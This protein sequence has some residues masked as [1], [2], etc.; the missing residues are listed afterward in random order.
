[1]R[2]VS[3]PSKNLTIAKIKKNIKKINEIPSVRGLVGGIL[4]DELTI[5]VE[6]AY[7][8]CSDV[9]V[10][11]RVRSSFSFLNTIESGLSPYARTQSRIY[12][13]DAT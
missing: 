11:T 9:T 6:S 7:I 10:L 12:L 3:S 13:Q 4:L 1:M 2:K 8:G 5:R